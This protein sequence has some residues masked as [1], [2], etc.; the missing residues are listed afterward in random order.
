[1]S[2]ASLTLA[3]MGPRRVDPYFI[4]RML[5]NMAAGQI[6]IYHGFTGPNTAPSTAC[7]TGTHAIGEASRMIEYGDCKVC[8][9]GGSES[10]IS[11]LG[12]AGFAQLRAL[13]ARGDQTASRPFNVDRD[14]FVMAEGSGIIVLEVRI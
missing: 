6:S 1:M 3:E 8:I 4:P 11:P 7:A 12:I 9:A 5:I 2:Q 14:G 13:S 10:S